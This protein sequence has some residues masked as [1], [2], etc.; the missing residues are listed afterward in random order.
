MLVANGWHTTK[1]RNSRYTMLPCVIFLIYQV[2]HNFYNGVLFL[3]FA[4]SNH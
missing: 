2:Y 1:P 4:N 3:R